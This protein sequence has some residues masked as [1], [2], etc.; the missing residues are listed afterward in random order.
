LLTSQEQRKTKDVLCGLSVS[1]VRKSYSSAIGFDNVKQ[2][3]E[4]S[5][6]DG[7]LGEIMIPNSAVILKYFRIGR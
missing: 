2:F 1:V 5:P 4:E 6:I 3:I 7:L